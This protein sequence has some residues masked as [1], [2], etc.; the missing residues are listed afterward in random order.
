[1]GTGNDKGLLRFDRTLVAQEALQARF[2]FSGDLMA[3]PGAQWSAG[4]FGAIAEFMRAPD[5]A[6]SVDSPIAGLQRP[7]RAGAVAMTPDPKICS[8]RPRRSVA[9]P[10]SGGTRCPSACRRTACTMNKRRVV[11]E[12]GPDRSAVRAQDRDAV[13][14]DLGLGLLQTDACVRTSDPALQHALRASEGKGLFDAGNY[15]AHG[16]L[17]REPHRVFVSRVGRVEVF[18]PIPP[19]PR[20]VAAGPATHILPKLLR[21]NRTH[22]ATTAIPAGF[23]PVRQCLS[24]PRYAR[25]RRSPARFRFDRASRRSR[26]CWMRSGCRRWLRH[27]ARSRV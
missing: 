5:E 25:F 8:S 22:A 16:H 1:M 14:F 23:V 7:P 11:T 13:L 15:R 20:D 21:A 18:Q 26:P 4:T 12:L 9:I 6:A 17:A 19:H 24:S 10:A 3:D 27:S 2:L